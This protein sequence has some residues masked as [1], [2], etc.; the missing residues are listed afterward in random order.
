MTTKEKQRAKDCRFLN[1]QSASSTQHA[2]HARMLLTC[3]FAAI[4]IAL[5]AITMSCS[6]GKSADTSA[7]SSST[8]QTIQ[9]SPREQLDLL[10]EQE[11]IAVSLPDVALPPGID[12]AAIAPRSS[13][14][15]HASLS[16]ADVIEL[17]ASRRETS[18][19]VQSPAHLE[20]IKLDIGDRI[21]AQH[22]YI[23]GR[24]AELQKRFFQ[25]N[26]AFERAHELD[27]GSHVI[28]RCLARSASNVGNQQQATR[29][30]RQ[31]LSR[32]PDD[33]EAIYFLGM[34]TAE[35][36]DFEEAIFHLGRKRQDFS[37]SPVAN[38]LADH[39][40][41]AALHAS[42]FDQAQIEIATELIA[43][44][45]PTPR[46]I[47][48]RRAIEAVQRQHAS[49]WLGIGDAQLRLGND[50][51]AIDAYRHAR[52]I[53]QQSGGSDATA[54]ATRT[55]YASLRA[56]RTYEAQRI[57]LN[58]LDHVGFD[59]M[60]SDRLIK[61]ADYL[62]QHS[63]STTTLTDCIEQFKPTANEERS[64]KVR[65]IAALQTPAEGAERLVEFLSDVP[66]DFAAFRS[67]I[68]RFESTSNENADRLD[69]LSILLGMMADHPVFAI[70]YADIFFETFGFDPE[71]IDALITGSAS[72]AN[73]HL[74]RSRI[75]LHANDSGSA[76]SINYAALN[77]SPDDASLF[78]NAYEIAAALHEPELLD[79]PRLRLD[80]TSINLLLRQSKA[81]ATLGESARAIALAR[82]AI[83]IDELKPGAWVQLAEARLVPPASARGA[84]I[85]LEKALEIDAT[86]EPAYATLLKIYNQHGPLESQ[87]AFESTWNRLSQ[88]LPR[89]ELR[90]TLIADQLLSQHR[91]PQGR[92][93]LLSLYEKAPWQTHIVDRLVQAWLESREFSAAAQWLDEQLQQR[94]NDP[95][96]L[97]AYSVI[98][99]NDGRADDA[100]ALLSH[101]LD[102][103]ERDPIAL[104]MLEWLYTAEGCEEDAFVLTESRLHNQPPAIGRSIRL[105]EL[106][107][108]NDRTTEAIRELVPLYERFNGL[109]QGNA[110]RLVNVVSR[111]NATETET[112]ESDAAQR[113]RMIVFRQ[114]VERWPDSPV[115]TYV[116]A[117]I[118]IAQVNESRQEFVELAE[119][120]LAHAPGAQD[121]QTTA[122]L[123]YRNLAEAVV[124]SGW[125]ELAGDFIADRLADERITNKDSR[126]LLVQVAQACYAAAGS[127]GKA[128]QVIATAADNNDLRHLPGEDGTTDATTEAEY[129]LSILCTLIGQHEAAEELLVGVIQQSPDY[130]M[131]F[132]NLGYRRIAEHNRSDD[133]SIKLVERALQLQPNDPNVLDT[134]AWLRYKQGR[135][136]NATPPAD[137]ED[138]TLN[139]LSAEELMS[140]AMA[141]L[142]ERNQTPSAEMLDHQGDIFWRIGDTSAAIESW[143]ASVA[144]IEDETYRNETL[145]SY[146][147]FQRGGWGILIYPGETLFDQL[148]TKQLQHT[149][150][151]LAAVEAGK[152]PD[153][154]NIF[155]ELL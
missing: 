144:M 116:D 48:E 38:L 100:K 105:L 102:V 31:L 59:D 79:D 14:S 131:A 141:I 101:R 124:Q 152:P 147:R 49:I 142:A 81:L 3:S 111:L 75:F 113:A 9:P 45:L 73:H 53:S 93:R 86:F 20:H 24:E 1:H 61:L 35:R 55:L 128:R 51:A 84:V 83:D 30:Y 155:E 91:Y 82:Q 85:A 120:M 46:T 115:Q 117:L 62:R 71:V 37:H 67:L 4:G 90:Q 123:P 54:I 33:S 103:N 109:T 65:L 108:S 64:R 41:V 78:V 133:D 150:D 13:E 39:A 153:I 136:E 112:A 57:F 72:T 8:Q 80:V 17:I 138:V 7:A 28:L 44:Q 137:G 15:N 97:R 66:D 110:K 23:A 77:D 40:L 106:Y 99:Q 43:Q 60:S 21:K 96:L 69:G 125:P 74:L 143:K 47:D 114:Y 76:W 134:A 146:L 58:T 122:I 154:A 22:F 29:T 127:V 12:T 19:T 89:S 11:V 119:K 98:L 16:F 132:N 26:R 130:A 70:D 94:P 6:G 32:L 92:E 18:A 87:E 36:G 148:H 68:A 149:K 145:E 107:A 52:A 135:F 27:P 10:S 104:R 56:G 118:A 126:Q 121:S 151:K 95:N 140:R 88:T 129:S 34:S 42:H 50:P 139:D 63:V 2:H 5:S 25:S